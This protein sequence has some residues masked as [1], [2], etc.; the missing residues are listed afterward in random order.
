MRD[1][2]RAVC[3]AL[4]SFSSA[5]CC[6]RT[7]KYLPPLP[8][9]RPL[10]GPGLPTRRMPRPIGPLHRKAAGQRLPLILKS[11][12]KKI[13]CSLLYTALRFQ[14]CIGSEYHQVVLLR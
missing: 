2:R 1:V 4:V 13:E 3:V 5:L 9:P 12:Q 7:G 11:R 10:H 14:D 6:P 8:A